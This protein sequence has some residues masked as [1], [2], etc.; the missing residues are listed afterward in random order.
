MHHNDNWSPQMRAV[1]GWFARLV[2][3]SA[4]IFVALLTAGWIGL[5]A[6]YLHV[7]VVNMAL[8]L[9]DAKHYVV[10][11]LLWIWSHAGR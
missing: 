9:V 6:Y 8:C 10:Q 2:T 1:R 3:V 7:A 5:I 4:V 11:F